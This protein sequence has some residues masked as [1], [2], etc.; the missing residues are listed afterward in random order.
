VIVNPSDPVADDMTGRL[1]NQNRT[2]KE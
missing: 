2:G 1:V